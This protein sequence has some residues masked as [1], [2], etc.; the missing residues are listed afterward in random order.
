[1]MKEYFGSEKATYSKQNGV[2]IPKKFFNPLSARNN[3]P[4]VLYAS[5]ID[6]KSNYILVFDELGKKSD[7]FKEQES[8]ELRVR[9][10]KR[11]ILPEEF[12][13]GLGLGRRITFAGLGD[14]FEIWNTDLW[15]AYLEDNRESMKK[16]Y[17]KFRKIF[18]GI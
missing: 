6:G 10:K 9:D 15:N 7:D 1:M 12:R 5:L 14:Y 4:F 18:E 11:I 17:K 2:V 3:S 13:K 8:L 16:Y